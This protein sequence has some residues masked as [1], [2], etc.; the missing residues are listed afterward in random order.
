MVGVDKKTQWLEIITAFE[1]HINGLLKYLFHSLEEAIFNSFLL[2]SKCN[3][4]KFY[5]I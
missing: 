2:Y 4:K 3:D 5:R 1:R